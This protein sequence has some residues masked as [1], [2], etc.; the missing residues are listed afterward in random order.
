[1]KKV[2]LLVGVATVAPLAL[3]ATATPAAAQT[4]SGIRNGYCGGNHAT[5]F[6]LATT[7]HGQQCYGYSGIIR[8]DM[9][10]GTYCPGNNLGYVTNTSPDNQTGTYFFRPGEGWLVTGPSDLDYV[11]YLS[12][13]TWSGTY[14]C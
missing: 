9:Y 14:T 4:V 2:R 8:P 13:V 6:D 1:M 10:A 11:N 3:A 7:Y 5:W 12:I